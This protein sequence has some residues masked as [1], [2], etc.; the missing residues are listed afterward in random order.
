MGLRLP[1][2]G[3]DRA[4]RCRQER[5]HAV[6]AGRR[7]ELT[8]EP[9]IGGRAHPR[10]HLLFLGRGRRQP[11]AILAA[12]ADPAGR[13]ASASTAHRRMRDAREAAHFQDR[14]PRGLARAAPFVVIETHHAGA[15]FPDVAQR[16]RAQD[17]DQQGERPDLEIA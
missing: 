1:A 15:S 3:L 10:Q 6:V 17:A 8:G 16:P 7:V 14:E 4:G 13:A 12:D 9:H 2:I 11:G 5:R